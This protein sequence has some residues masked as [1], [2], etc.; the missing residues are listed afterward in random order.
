MWFEVL[1]S[2]AIITVM[3]SIPGFAIFG[4]NKLTVGNGYRRNMDERWER[5]MYQRDFRLTG[6][7]YKCNGLESIPDEK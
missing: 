3:L 1:P 2:A 7:P 4:L 6:N 5:V